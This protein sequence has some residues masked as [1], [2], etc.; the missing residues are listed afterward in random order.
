MEDLEK[1]KKLFDV[2]KSK[3]P[4]HYLPLY[5]PMNC[6]LLSILLLI[7]PL[8]LNASQQH[9][10]ITD[11]N[12][13]YKA[14]TQ[15]GNLHTNE[16]VLVVYDVDNTLL[17]ANQSLGSD[18]WYEWQSGLPA[19]SKD[20]V[21][22][23]PELY[24]IVNL[25]HNLG[26]MHPPQPDLPTLVWK[27]QKAGF[28]S[29]VITARNPRIRVA[30]LRELKANCYSFD[31]GAPPVFRPGDVTLFDFTS[32]LSPELINR[33]QLKKPGEK[34]SY[35]DGLVLASGQHK[36]AM[37][38]V[39]LSLAESK[40]YHYKAVVFI[41]DKKKNVDAV[42]EALRD[43]AMEVHT[44]EYTREERTPFDSQQAAR[45]WQK[46]RG[47]LD[48]IFVKTKDWKPTQKLAAPEAAALSLTLENEMEDESLP[49]TK[50]HTIQG[51]TNLPADALVNK[52]D[53]SGMIGC[54]VK[55]EAIVTAVYTQPGSFD[56][57]VVQE[58]DNDKDEDPFS[59]EGIFVHSEGTQVKTGDLVRVTG[60][61]KEDYGQTLIKA[62]NVKTLASDQPLPNP[63][64]VELPTAT[65]LT[66]KV[67]KSK[68]FLPN[69]EAY[70]GMRIQ[71]AQPL[72]VTE[73]YQLGKF[74]EIRVSAKG[75]LEQFTQ[76]N[77]PSI[78][79]YKNHLR[80][81]G[82]RSLVF[83]DG[84]SER[85]RN[86]V[87][88]PSL[89]QDQ[90]LTS[91]QGIRMGDTYTNTVGVLT[92]GYNEY[93]IQ[94]P[95]TV[96]THKNPRSE[97]P[98]VEGRLKVAS[99]NVLNFFTT[100]DA[101]DHRVGANQSL[102]PRGARCKDE[103]ERQL[104]KLTLAISQLDA[105]IIALDEL[106]ND[107]VLNG[108][109]PLPSDAQADRGIAVQTLV[110]SLNSRLKGSRRYDW[111]Q[112]RHNRLAAEFVG[113]DAIAVGFIYDSKTIEPQGDPEIL[114]TYKS[115]SF[116]DPLGY[117]KDRNRPAVAQTFIEKT[118]GETFTMVANH[119]KSKSP[120]KS[121]DKTLDSDTDKNDGQGS[122]SATRDEAAKILRDWLA[123]D[124]TASGDPDFLVVGDLNAYAMEAPVVTLLAGSDAKSGTDDDYINLL[125]ETNYSYVYDGQAGSLD[126]ALASPSLKPQITGAS[127]WH[128]NADEP[129][130]YDYL[131]RDGRDPS[132][133]SA[134]AYRSSDHDPVVIG[135]SLKSQH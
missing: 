126:H 47:T 43:V 37:L 62:D 89:G 133:Y 122:W 54:R 50:I 53:K 67:G 13:I 85:Y 49:I 41:D 60:P 117:N 81:I 69:L 94:R 36:G 77:S 112:P 135:I 40:G 56:G 105:D 86:P 46:L 79:G 103:Y 14:I 16:S 82:Q 32:Y 96:L 114:E 99:F 73:M 24:E 55:I 83:D 107:F 2:E 66:V 57:F 72:T 65:A 23:K 130:L 111:I 6:S 84:L 19:N 87:F 20:K 100:F 75:R 64:Q 90:V 71:I 38:R 132:L 7:S 28:P 48:S 27:L 131:L 61:V 12:E 92:Y 97:A 31:R 26:E 115:K 4:F 58:E 15:L 116:V 9:W 104:K 98:S 121:P 101:F 109:S 44:Y 30:T 80:T 10:N 93:R 78:T 127:I 3:A 29:M 128:C 18:Q 21:A 35:G 25:L 42:W 1:T 39:I 68:K 108:A 17:A 118:S 106:E 123:S 74:G 129:V 70:E 59:S 120:P 8:T 52:D 63:A 5:I 102:E 34:A 95:E 45:D 91:S 125:G 88:V 22:E 110:E 51:S 113:S 119:L 11:A 33:L 134:D 124:P 76:S